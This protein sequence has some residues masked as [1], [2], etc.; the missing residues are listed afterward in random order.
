MTQLK[1]NSPTCRAI[2]L[3]RT[4][5]LNNFMN[6][7]QVQNFY[8][9]PSVS[10]MWSMSIFGKLACGTDTNLV[11]KIGRKLCIL[12][13]TLTITLL[14]SL[15]CDCVNFE[16]NPDRLHLCLRNRRTDLPFLP[17]A[18]SFLSITSSSSNPSKI[19]NTK[20]ED[21]PNEPYRY[22]WFVKPNK[23]NHPTIGLSIPPGHTWD[24]SFQTTNKLLINKMGLI[25]CRVTF[26]QPYENTDRLNYSEEDESED[27]ENSKST[28]LLC[29]YFHSI[30]M[31]V[32]KCTMKECGETYLELDPFLQ[33]IKTHENE[34]QYCCHLCHKSFPT[35]KDLGYHQY[36][37]SLYPNQGP[38][39]GP[40]YYRCVKCMNKY[41]T[42]SA[43]EHH[44]ATT[45]HRYPCPHC[46]KV[47]T[48]E[49]R[50]LLV[51]GTVM[52]HRCEVC[53]KCFKTEHYL[54]MHSL[55]HT[56]EKPFQCLICNKSFNRKDKLKRHDLIHI[57]FKRFKCPFKNH[58]GC[59]KEFN[60]PDKLKAHILTHNGMK[61]FKCKKCHRHFSRRSHLRDH[62]RYHN[63][64]YRF[65]CEKCNKAFLRERRLKEHK[66]VGDTSKQPAAKR[67]TQTT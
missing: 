55:I 43:L 62:E 13:F 60:R 51:H 3:P 15:Y 14:D 33:H 11:V 36:S 50:H 27:E 23:T 7:S 8:A 67:T 26:G 52:M 56:G 32:Y 22:R 45:S 30:H 39:P 63:N 10:I 58:T 34:M 4:S 57:P 44:M 65:R 16:R 29:P 5:L 21:N 41:A 19:L 24:V 25:Y 61:P 9:S 53:S 2:D 38:R 40:R 20:M 18:D 12:Y 46:N 31:S 49:R 28:V 66:C 1:I 37:H 48:C 17:S 54:K 42:A 35:L 6:N 47:F 59:M 64:D